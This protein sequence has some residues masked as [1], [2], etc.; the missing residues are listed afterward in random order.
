MTNLSKIIRQS[1]YWK[2]YGIISPVAFIMVASG[3][4][5]VHYSKNDDLI[6]S[7][8]ILLLSSAIV[9]WFWTIRVIA[10]LTSAFNSIFNQVSDLRSDIK[11]V[12]DDI[13]QLPK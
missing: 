11:D 1:R 4:A 8:W 12:R 6:L 5:G 13:R 10:E 9:W 2:M 3:V 7:S